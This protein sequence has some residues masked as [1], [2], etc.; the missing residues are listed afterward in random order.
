MGSGISAPGSWIPAMKLRIR[1]KWTALNG[2]I[3]QIMGSGIKINSVKRGNI[4]EMKN[5]F[6][7]PVLMCLEMFTSS[8]KM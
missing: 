8:A 7:T 2:I 1:A 5:V 4:Q 6:T 3:N